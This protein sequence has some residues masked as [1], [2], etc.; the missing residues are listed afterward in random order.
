MSFYSQI[1]SKLFYPAYELLRRRKTFYYFCEYKTNEQLSSDEIAELSFIKLKEMLVYCYENIPYYKEIWDKESIDVRSF[2]EAGDME[3]LPFL[4]KE[5]IKTRYDDLKPKMY[6]GDRYTKTTGGSSGEPLKFEYSRESNDR[7]TAVAWR[8][9]EWGGAKIGEKTLYLW[10]GDVLPVSKVKKLKDGVYNFVFRRKILNTFNMRDDNLCWYVEQINKFKPKRIV[11][12]TTPV[13]MLSEYI[14]KHKIPIWVPGSLL[15]G[16]E[17]LSE[18][19]R[20]LINSAFKSE[21]YNTYGSREVMLMAS[22]CEYHSGLHITS[23]HLYLEVVARCGVNV[24]GEQGEV[25]VTD[26]HNYFMPLIRYKNGDLATYGEK[27]CKCG[28]PFPKLHEINGRVLSI[29]KTKSGIIL[30]GEYF[31]HLIKDFDEVSGY[32]VVQENYDEVIVRIILRNGAK[33]S[34][35]MQLLCEVI[36]KKLNYELQVKIEFVEYLEKTLSGKTLPVISRIQE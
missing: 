13:V 29:I 14:L 2:T 30:P 31:P 1:F 9:Y 12:Y 11:A 3:K 28:L 19:Q 18:E 34:E 26:L 23:D 4:T 5:I 25:V 35:S 15:T 8:G 24:T 7:R 27:E 16:A 32:Q 21:V 22:E 6:I 17:G 10:G 33:K 20:I 36:Q